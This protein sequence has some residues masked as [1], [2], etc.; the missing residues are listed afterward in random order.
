MNRIKSVWVCC[1][2][3]GFLG[4]SYPAEA[5][6]T[7][8]ATAYQAVLGEKRSQTLGAGEAGYYGIVLQPDRSYAAFC[9]EPSFEGQVQVGACG[10]DVRTSSNVVIS[11]DGG[12]E[13]TPKGGWSVTFYMLH[14][15]DAIHFLR[16][17]NQSPDATTQTVSF[18]VLETTLASPWFFVSSIGGYDAYVEIRNQSWNPVTLTVTAWTMAPPLRPAK[19][20]MI[21]PNDTAIVALSSLGI[22]SGS[23]SLTITH[24]AMPGTIVA[25][26]TSLSATTGLS[27]EAAFTP[28]MVWSTF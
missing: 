22:A 9:W 4:A 28:R 24:N 11:T 2:V 10:L 7:S 21:G 25:N 19:T 14:G 12:G 26:T 27:I 16:I 20:L 18:M 15:N 1:V 23:G 3:L 17:A 5:A 6:N 13:P 8:I